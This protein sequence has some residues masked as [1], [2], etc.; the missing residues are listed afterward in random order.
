MSST[1]TLTQACLVTGDE[2][3]ES[4]RGRPLTVYL[5]G[6][7]VEEPVDHPMIRPSINAVAETYGL[8]VREPELA[9]AISPFTGER[10]SRFLHVCTGTD[11]LVRQNKM[12]RK[13]GQLTGTCFQRCVGMDAL[14]TLTRLLS[15]STS[16]T[17]P[18][19]ISALWISSP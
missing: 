19:T 6:E 9:S 4:L 15:R 1:D 3:I 7:R 17:A 14:N 8:A 10:I 12:Q 2:Y 16:G 18:P 11:D 13:L 5:F